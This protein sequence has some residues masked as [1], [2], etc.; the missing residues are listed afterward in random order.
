MS[1]TTFMIIFNLIILSLVG[2]IIYFLS[3][4]FLT[5]LFNWNG[6]SI[7]CNPIQMI[8]L[9]ATFFVIIFLFN[10]SMSSF[11]NKDMYTLLRLS[12]TIYSCVMAIFSLESTK[13]VSGV[14]FTIAVVF[15]PF[16]PIHLSINTWQPIDFFT[17]CLIIGLY[18]YN[19]IKFYQKNSNGSAT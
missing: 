14:F 2:L 3:K 19:Q 11:S 4:K 15:N 16:I 9:A 17:A 13:L 5:K 12:V 8:Q 1:F 6:I 7:I 18:L 10:A